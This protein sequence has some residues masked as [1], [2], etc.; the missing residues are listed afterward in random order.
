MDVVESP[1]NRFKSTTAGQS[2]DL[3][4]LSNV[5]GAAGRRAVG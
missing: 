3:Q 1:L 5:E 4:G 2:G